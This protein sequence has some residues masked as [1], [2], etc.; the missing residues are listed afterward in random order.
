MILRY[1]EKASSH[2]RYEVPAT[3]EITGLSAVS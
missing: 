3:Q 1:I 2:A